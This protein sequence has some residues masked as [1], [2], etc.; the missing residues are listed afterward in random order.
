MKLLSY[1]LDQSMEPRLAFSLGGFAVDV[2]RASLWMKENRN[3]PSYLT[4]ASSMT[5]VLQDWNR[6]FPLL[7][8]LAEAIQGHELANLSV[9]GRAVA[10]LESD[11]VYFAPVPAPPSLRYFTAF[12]AGKTFAFGNTQTL[13]GHNQTL[14]HTGLSTQG[15]IAAIV[16]GT[17]T[18]LEIAGYCI[19]NN[20]RDTRVSPDEGLAHGLATSLGP[21]LITADELESHQLGKSLGLDMQI[22]LNGRI[23]SE[24]R[25]KTMLVS[26]PELIHQAAPTNIQPGDIFCSGSPQDPGKYEPGNPGDLIEIEIQVLGTL[27]TTIA[28][29]TDDTVSAYQ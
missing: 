18:N 7:K 5:L 15:E 9:Y 17:G 19:V 13:L 3:T 25:F 29:Q 27:S 22:R 4:L 21:Y 20:W 10:L 24:S 16:A 6:S 1:G 23:I 8:N 11:I 2:M 28:Q 26:F 14:I 12:E